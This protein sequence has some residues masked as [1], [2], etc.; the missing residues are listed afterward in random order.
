[1][2]NVKSAKAKSAKAKSANTK[3]ASVKSANTK[4]AVIPAKP[5]VSPPDET[6][7]QSAFQPVSGLWVALRD[8]PSPFSHDEALLLCESFPGEWVCWLPGHGEITLSRGQF[9]YL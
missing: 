6:L 7:A 5:Q 3:S 4:S 1:M 2:A 8:E 9:H